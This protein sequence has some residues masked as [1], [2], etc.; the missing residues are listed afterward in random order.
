MHVPCSG[1]TGQTNGLRKHVICSGLTGQTNGLR[2]HVICSGLTGQTRTPMQIT[3][4]PRRSSRP[5]MTV[6]ANLAMAL[7]RL[8]AFP[9]LHSRSGTR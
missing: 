7:L 9:A 2:K 4:R 5:M 1:L 6:T 3:G 8:R